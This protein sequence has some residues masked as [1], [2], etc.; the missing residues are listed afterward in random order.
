MQ[1]QGKKRVRLGVIKGNDHALKFWT[2]RG[3]AFYEEKLGDKWTV[4]CYEKVL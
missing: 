2:N 1:D 3:F 4:L